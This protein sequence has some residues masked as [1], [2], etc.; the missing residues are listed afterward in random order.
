MNSLE[1]W[2]VKKPLDYSSDPDHDPDSG[3]FNGIFTTEGIGAF[4]RILSDQLPWW[5]FAA[6]ERL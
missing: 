3:I 6:A 2:D 5:R 1:W 4:V